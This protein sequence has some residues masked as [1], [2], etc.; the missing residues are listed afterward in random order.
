M[1]PHRRRSELLLV[2]A[3]LLWGAIANAQT[4]SR[5]RVTRDGTVVWRTDASVPLAT[6]QA[7]ET[8]EVT[9]Q[10]TRWFEV[11]LPE[12]VAGAGAVGL[13]ARSQLLLAPE[14]PAPPMKVLRGDPPPSPVQNARQGRPASQPTRSVPRRFP[15]AY[16]SVDAA[17]QTHAETFEQVSTFEENVDTGELRT[18]YL[19]ERQW[20]LD[21][22]VA[23]TVAGPFA[24]GGAVEVFHRGTSG[25]TTAS[26]PHPFFFATPRVATI[27]VSD[28]DQT[29]VGLHFQARG[30]WFVGSHLH[31][32]VG[33]GPSL[34]LVKQRFVTDI[35]YSDSYPYDS[36]TLEG[37]DTSEANGRGVGFN[38]DVDV[39]Y[40][41]T[42][43][44]GV[45]V[46]GRYSRADV[47]IEG[48]DS[49]TF[50]LRVGGRTIGVG[51]RVRF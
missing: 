10:S 28:L 30:L 14:S 15:S 26:I 12:R 45:G 49:E 18:T 36:I 3:L 2:V 7:G 34:F 4:V 5:G 43:R 41:F 16:L 35:T 32:S 33:A 23:G 27:D 1:N 13:I 46:I 44:V 51:L 48:D 21:A 50:D 40:Y 38:A 24:L 19:P 29:Q 8:L 47:T 17:L 31:V 22:A 6:V 42:R 11:R 37:V 39:A 25:S 20:G 9:G